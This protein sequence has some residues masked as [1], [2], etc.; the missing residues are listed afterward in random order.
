MVVNT[1]LPSFKVNVII[2]ISCSTAS[3]ISQEGV[4]KNFQGITFTMKHG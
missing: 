3:D 2:P 4:Q 1:H